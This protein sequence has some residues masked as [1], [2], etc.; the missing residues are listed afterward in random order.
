MCFEQPNYWYSYALSITNPWMNNFWTNIDRETYFKRMYQVLYMQ[1]SAAWNQGF[2]NT[3][4]NVVQTIVFWNLLLI[5]RNPFYPSERRSKW[6]VLI[7]CVFVTI[8]FIFT[9]CDPIPTSKMNYDDYLFNSQFVLDLIFC[10]VQ[11]AVLIPIY[12]RLCKNG[13]SRVLKRKVMT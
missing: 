5:L 12:M 13:T 6:Y 3:I 7:I 9:F 11:L 4:L 8:Y 10:I 1:D 2:F